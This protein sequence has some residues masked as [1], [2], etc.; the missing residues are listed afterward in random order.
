MIGFQWLRATTRWSVGLL[1]VLPSMALVAAVLV[2]RGPDGE[3][4]FS[5]FPI[6]L[7]TFDPFAWTCARNSLI[8]ATAVT[9][10]AVTGGV[11]IGGAISG[12]PVRGR[13]VLRAAM[14]SM[15]A[16]QPACLALGLC[17]IWGASDPWGW[18]TSMRAAAT[19][20]LSLETWN[21]WPLWL[22]WICASAPSAVALV[23]IATAAARDRI[24]PAWWDAAR[25]AGAGPFRVWSSVTWPMIRPAAARA[26]A[27]VFSMAL[28]DPG[29]PL[30]LGLRRTLAFQIVEAA[31]RPDPF[32]RIAVWAAMA[33]AFSMAGRWI[34]RWCGGPPRLEPTVATLEGGRARRMPL[35]SG[36]GFAIGV[37][38]L[39]AFSVGLGWLPF[40]GL[41]R[42]LAGSGTVTS[43]AEGAPVSVLIAVFRRAT[44]PPVMQAVTHS[45]VLGLE[46]GL[47]VLIVSWMLR[48]DPGRRLTSTLGSRLVGR[49]ALMPPMIQGVGWLAVLSLGARALR[50]LEGQ[51]GLTGPLA[52]SGGLAAEL[53]VA[54]NPWPILSAVVG[55]S[56]GIR[57]LQSWRRTA[58]FRPD[59]SR[60]SLDA[61]LVAGASRRRARA[62][63]AVL[64]G[65]CIGELALPA[66]M[67]AVNLAPAL[68]F[69]PW[70][71]GRTAA[72]AM[73]ILADGPPNARLQ[74]AAL[75]VF[76]IAGSLAGLFAARLAPA[77]P[78][79]WDEDQP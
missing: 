79:E 32:P 48:P 76:L 42:I 36:T 10:L 15:L 19:G 43:L 33:A 50:S 78:P 29:A 66:A 30:I 61:A 45:L 39:V 72:P 53:D 12:R 54:R 74:A 51:S 57:L 56:V 25:L 47:G 62:L 40:L 52:R 18:P 58:E 38:S 65:R 41:V 34:L 22:F 60:S 11:A 46:V 71:D 23:A 7:L 14:S 17:G 35:T 55:L 9:V 8:F 3:A 67:A 20:R 16:A 64:P 2:D 27:I 26:A 1:T 68:L 13:A 5:L 59:E 69:T 21:G 63:A 73:L 77:P 24:E 75:A 6:A 31:A 44:D 70:T 37:G 4:R 49:F 28:V